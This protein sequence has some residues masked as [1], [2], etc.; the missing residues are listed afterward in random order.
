MF[1]KIDMSEYERAEHYKYY[2]EIIKTKCNLTVN[3]D[4]TYFLHVLKKN[5]LKFYQSFVYVIMKAVNDLPQFKMALDGD[6]NLGFYDYCNPSYT[7][8]HKDDC[9]FSDLWTQWSDDFFTFYKAMSD[10]MEKY[11]FVKGV[12]GKPDKPENFIPVSNLPWISFASCSYDT[13]CESDMLFPVIVFGKYFEDNGKT[14]LPFT[15]FINHAAADGYHICTLINKI[16]KN[17]NDF[18]RFI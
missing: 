18:E 3:I 15:V 1:N 7:V 4:I 16:E 13:Y 5:N 12:K 8:F 6:K 14:L 11:R 2:R 10:D 9:T 17:C